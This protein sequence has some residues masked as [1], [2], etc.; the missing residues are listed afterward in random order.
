[1]PP[2]QAILTR[3][4]FRRSSASRSCVAKALGTVGGHSATMGAFNLVLRRDL[5]GFDIRTVARLPG[6]SGGDARQGSVWWGGGLGEKGHVTLGIDVLDRQ[7]IVGSAREHSRSEWIP[8]GDFAD[9]KNVSVGGNT[10][11]V[12]DRS[13]ENAPVP[14][15]GVVRPGARLH[16][17][18]SQPA[19]DSFRR[20]RL[21]LCLWK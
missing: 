13:E 19:G 16:G 3:F 6:K 11:F 1:M 17:P 21:R 2:P 14:G 7:E 5:D 10:V 9:A 12:F 4:R 15:A 20:H 8:G 18:A